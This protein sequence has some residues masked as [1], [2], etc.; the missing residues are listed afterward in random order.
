MGR[1]VATVPVFVVACFARVALR[2][3]FISLSGWVAGAMGSSTALLFTE[4][5][6]S[7][8][9]PAIA[10]TAVLPMAELMPII[11]AQILAIAVVHH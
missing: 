9:A 5:M 6:T 10:Y 2:M 7:S 3:N 1:V 4:E 11:C 8:N